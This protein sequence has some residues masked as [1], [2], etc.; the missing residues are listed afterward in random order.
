MTTKSP[1]EVQKEDA[2]F[3]K[4][5]RSNSNKCPVCF[6]IL[7]KDK[8]SLHSNVVPQYLTCQNCNLEFSPT[9]LTVFWFG[10]DA[11]VESS[12]VHLDEEEKEEKEDEA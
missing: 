1:K 5:E 10:F 4:S 3:R 12:Y 8:E 7:S 9:Y 2:S 11:G 6:S